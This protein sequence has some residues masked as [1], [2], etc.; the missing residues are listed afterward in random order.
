LPD[1]DGDPDQGRFAGFVSQGGDLFS[2]GKTPSEADCAIFPLEWQQAGHPDLPMIEE[3]Y[4]AFRREI[5]DDLKAVVFFNNDSDE[6]LSFEGPTVVFRTS[7]SGSTRQP[8]E[9]ALPGW[10]VDFLEKYF[11][12]ELPLQKTK[13]SQPVVG[14][15]GYVDYD[16]R[17]LIA[18]AQGVLKNAAGMTQ[19]HERLRGKAVRLLCGEKNRL[20]A[21]V[22]IRN[23][24]WGGG[25]ADPRRQY[26]DNIAACDYALVARGRGNFSY[27]LYEILSCGKIPVFV[28]TDCVLPYDRWIDY[29]DLFVWVEERDLDRIVDIVAEFHESKSEAELVER[30]QHLR[31]VY[32]QWLSPVGFHKNLW[33]LLT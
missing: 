12:G 24:F 26:V 25:C 33:R 21:D 27:R 13:R 18:K 19:P 6:M 15:C 23:G 29:R 14:Y 9:H 7:F 3:A 1:R 10:S 17:S 22:V 30:Q 11:G 5:G 2:L 28:N 20:R 31:H 16:H 32:Q 4:R 8:T